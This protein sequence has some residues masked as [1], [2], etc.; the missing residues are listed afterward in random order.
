VLVSRVVGL[1]LLSSL[2]LQVPVDWRAL[3]VDSYPVDARTQIV[4]ARDTA[5]A[6]PSDA[7]AAGQLGLVLHAWEQYE[8]AA[9]AYARAHT[10]APGDAQ[11]WALS[12]TLATRMGRHDLAADHFGRAAALAPSPLL[13]LRHADALLDSSQ[14]EAART[15]YERA[16]A[17]PDAEPAAR[18]GLGRLAV[19]SGDTPA[20]RTQFERAVALVPTFGAAHYAL[21]LAQRKAGD[22]AAARASIG[23]QQQCLACWP[24]PPDPYAARVAAVRTDAAALLQRGIDSASRAEDATAIALH[25]DALSRNADLLQAHV[26][27]ITLYARTGNLPKAEAHYRAVIARGSQLAEAHR[28]FGLALLASKDAARA[29][30]VLRLAAAGNPQDAEVHNALGLIEESRGDLPAAETSYRKAVDANPRVRA[31]RFNLARV[32]VNTGRLDDALVQLARLTEPDDAESVRY[33]FAASA[34]HVRKGDIA[35]GRRLSEDAL[36]RARRHGLVDMATTIERELQ[37]IK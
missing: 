6:R 24:M 11:W 25:E 31:L 23:R 22:L 34:V 8:L 35:T 18:Y 30:P 20:A 14:L 32:L 37:K 33:V 26:N 1:L 36:A 3:P 16:L 10:L 5:V 4:A 9:A 15:A 12:G 13:L 21:A 19:A 28:T 7:E 17:V 27:L 29:E 2:T